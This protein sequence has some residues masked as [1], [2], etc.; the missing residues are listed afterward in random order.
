MTATRDLK[1]LPDEMQR[2]FE[3]TPD[4]KLISISV[5]RRGQTYVINN[6]AVVKMQKAVDKW[7]KRVANA[8]PVEKAL[9]LTCDVNFSRLAHEPD[10]YVVGLP[11]AKMHVPV[12]TAAL[13]A[14]VCANCSTRSDDELIEIAR[15]RWGPTLTPV[16]EGNA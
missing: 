12:R 1:P 15:K 10:A 2:D 11:T 16:V 8:K 3:V 14:G 5:V 7:R 6:C 13:I 4:R 9:C